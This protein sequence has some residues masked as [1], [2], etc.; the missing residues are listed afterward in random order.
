M[1]LRTVIVEDER[2]S[3]ERLIDLLK[4]LVD[5]SIIGE[6]ADGETAVAM[7]DD[8]R[9]DLVFLDIHIPGA[10]GFE[11]LARVRHHPLVIFV[12]A[13]DEYAVRAFDAD[14]VDYILKPS[15]R[16]RVAAAVTRARERGRELDRDLLERLR[17]VM[18]R[19]TRMK[20]FAVNLADEILIIPE[21]EVYCFRAEDKGVRLCTRDRQF[22]FDMTLKEL[23][24]SL[25]MEV[26]CRIHKSCIVSLD[27]VRRMERWF[28]GDLIVQLQDAGK[29]R[30]KVGPAYRD[31]LRR[32]L[33]L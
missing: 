23:E 15:S 17:A 6:A 21:S 4:G 31:E 20:R 19:G 1:V 29:T 28:H 32:R 2:P 33:R 13:Y 12:T 14:A 16:E 7:I 11:V 25:D 9:P 10:N 18:E 27:K 26:F 22:D 5:L 30:V 8:L 3:R 24:L